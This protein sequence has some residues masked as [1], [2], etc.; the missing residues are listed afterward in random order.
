M[1]PVHRPPLHAA[2]ALILLALGPAAHAAQPVTLDR[3]IAVVEQHP[4]LLSELHRRVAVVESNA[5]R[6]GTTIDQAARQ[7]LVHQSLE[8]M[9]DEILI[10]REAESRQLT[11][12]DDELERA[13]SA[14]AAI[15]G[16]TPEQLYA[17]A[18]SI[19]RRFDCRHSKTRRTIFDNRS[20]GRSSRRLGSAGWRP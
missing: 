11:V 18:G 14:V 5:Q 15:N 20:T 10:G 4:V 8:A 17:E 9:I 2:L 6:S 3:V 7:Q 19:G 12:S 13:V 16:L 1:N